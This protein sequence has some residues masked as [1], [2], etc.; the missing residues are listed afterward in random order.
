MHHYFYNLSSAKMHQKCLQSLVCF[1]TKNNYLFNSSVIKY[2][3]ANKEILE[4]YIFQKS[5]GRNRRY[6][7]IFKA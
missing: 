7:N 5:Y 1:T 6:Y 4:E 2:L 3:F